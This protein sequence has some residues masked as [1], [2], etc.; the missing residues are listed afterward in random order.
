M[1]DLIKKIGTKN[2]IT[3]TITIVVIIICIVGGAIIYHNFFYK[4]SFSEIEN[5]MTTAAK[6]YYTN[7]EKK[8]PNKFGQTNNIN[9]STLISG[10]YMQPISEYLKDDEIL[11]KGSVNVTNNN[12]KY[13]YTPL[14]DCGKDYNYKTL[15]NYIQENE[16]IVTSGEGLYSLNEELVFRGEKINN[17]VKFNGQ[18]WRIVKITNDKI[19]LIYNDE[20]KKVIWDNRYNIE[21]LSNAGINNY[22]VS[23][24]RDSINDLYK[25]LFSAKNQL[26]LSNF[27]LEIGKVG[28]NDNDKSGEI[29]KTTIVENQYIGLLPIYDYMNASLDTNCN[30]TTNPSCSNYNYLINY[31]Y[32]WWT[33]TGDKNTSFYVYQISGEEGAYT[34]KSSSNGYLRPI[35]AITPDA[36]YVSGKGTINKPYTFR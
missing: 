16:K 24:I 23:R 8:L 36:L 25:N 35:I 7:H 18:N 2:L 34:I 14:L 3:I 13:R 20:P 19:I 12:G 33:I 30:S 31:E 11:C 28:E 15:L 22:L 5:I 9:V 17:Y 26:L 32:N 6:N 21:K 1:D 27:N 4:K 29:E 10:E